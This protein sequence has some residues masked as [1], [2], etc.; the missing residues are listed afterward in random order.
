VE[1][2]GALDLAR[3]L[4]ASHAEVRVE[5]V[6]ESRITIQDGELRGVVSGTESGFAVRVLVAGGWGFASSN[7]LSAGAWR[8]ATERA[9]QLGRAA[10]GA[11]SEPVRLAEAPVLRAQEHWRPRIDP[12][13]VD[14]EEKVA[15][16]RRMDAGVRA[17]EGIRTVDTSCADSLVTK[18]FLDTDGRDLRWS[19]V[20][21]VA[22]AHFTARSEGHLAG[23]SSRVGGTQ[24][25]ELF[26]AEDPVAKAVAAARSTVASLGAR[27]PRGGRRTIVIDPELAGVFAHEAVGHASEADLVCAGESCFRGKMGARLGIEGL[28]IRDDSTVPGAFGSFPFDDNGVRGQSRP[29][30]QD[31]VLAGYLADREHAAELGVAPNGSAR[32]Q[33]FHSR[34]LV[35]M[36]NTLIAPGDRGD[37]EVFEGIADGVYCL[38]SRG[39]QVDTARGT[40]LFN[41]QEAYAIRGGEVAEPLR[42]V[43]L[44]GDIL[45]TLRNISALGR[46]A[47]LGDPG[48]CGKGQWVPVCDGGPLVRIESCLVGGAA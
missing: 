29:I 33:D 43:S 27:A 32:A 39:G 23:R 10:A 36:S 6:E 18:R 48:Y 9:V 47:R 5:R 26:A 31:G 21:T 13:S 16:L 40:F 22:Q 38:G 28:H 1:P 17:V 8:A 44:T 46:H 37:E 3:T 14:P 41:A 2:E 45:G 34:P 42:D 11:R 15:L 35:R 19:L 12:Q 7:D 4:G 20:R 24:G 30:L 25:W